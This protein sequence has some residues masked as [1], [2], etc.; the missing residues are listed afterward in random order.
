MGEERM[1]DRRGAEL[2][3]RRRDAAPARVVRSGRLLFLR[4]RWVCSFST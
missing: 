3:E 2:H 1:D 4:C